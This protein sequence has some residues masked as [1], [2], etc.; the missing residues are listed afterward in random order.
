[1]VNKAHAPK[2]PKV[3]TPDPKWTAQGIEDA[4]QDFKSI[5]YDGVDA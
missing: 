1:V 3:I 2:L 5:P 4:K